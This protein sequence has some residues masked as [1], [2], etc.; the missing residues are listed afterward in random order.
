MTATRQTFTSQYR[1]ETAAC[2]HI[3]PADASRWAD[4]AIYD[5]QDLIADI[6]DLDPRQ[7]VGRLVL[8][9][10]HSPARLV[11]ATIALAAMCD[12]H[13]GT[14]DALAWLNTLAVAA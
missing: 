7:I 10:Q 1:D 3:T 11:V 4:Q 2:P 8:W 5:A 12:P 13:R 9:G 14:G 6:R